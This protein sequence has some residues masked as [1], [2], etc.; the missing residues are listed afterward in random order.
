ME[1]IYAYSA[2]ALMLLCWLWGFAY[3][4]LDKYDRRYIS[5]GKTL[6]LIILSALFW[7]VILVRKP[8]LLRKPSELFERDTC[9]SLIER[10]RDKIRRELKPCSNKVRFGDSVDGNLI[11]KFEFSADAI[12][13]YL[14]QRTDQDGYTSLNDYSE[15]REWVNKVDHTNNQAS[16]VPWVWRSFKL[17]ATEL[18]E[19]GIGNCFCEACRVQ[20]ENR[21][22]KCGSG[23]GSSGWIA[24]IVKCPQEH[25]VMKFDLMKP[26][27]SR[28]HNPRTES[29][30]VAST[31]PHVPHFLKKGK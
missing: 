23:N 21:E 17:L 19:K 4:G 11:G 5:W 6:A 13:A 18:I 27:C 30:Q 1:Y 29:D 9:S 26:F 3:I 14:A 12:S 15:I 7:P 2:I 28:K 25:E 8:M 16:E 31:A 10:E 24:I 22:L 20:Y